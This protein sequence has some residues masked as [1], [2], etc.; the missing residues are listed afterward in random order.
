MTLTAADAKQV[1]KRWPIFN[2][3]QNIIRWLV[4]RHMEPGVYVLMNVSQFRKGRRTKKARQ[5]ELDLWPGKRLKPVLAAVADCGRSPQS[6]FGRL[7]FTTKR[8]R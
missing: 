1:L 3:D 6:A 8:S 4:A 7:V 2:S 5:M